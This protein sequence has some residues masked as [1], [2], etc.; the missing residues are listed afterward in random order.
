MTTVVEVES[1]PSSMATDT[2]TLDTLSTN[3]AVIKGL[4]VLLADS[5]QLMAQ[6]HLAHWNVEG[7]DFF[8]LHTVFQSQYEELFEA[9]DEIAERLRA[10]DAF[11]PGG[12]KRLARLT[13]IEES[14]DA[15]PAKD[16]VASLLVA[17]ELLISNAFETRRAAAEA[18]DAETEDMVIG[19]IKEHQKTTWM[20]KSFLK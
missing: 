5:Y 2:N 3:A 13:D 11:A 17:H 16:F 1:P 15:V 20:L 12:L 19:R 9:I 10:M 18:G 8:Q 6:T 14:S 7:T 4:E